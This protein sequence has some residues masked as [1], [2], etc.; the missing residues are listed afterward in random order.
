MVEWKHPYL[1]VFINL[2]E[3]ISDMFIKICEFPSR[4]AYLTASKNIN[5]S[6]I[7]KSFPENSPAFLLNI[8]DM[9]VAN[10]KK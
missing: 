5:L 6:N 10:F 7:F 4:I 1:W 2:L 9:F 3:N 8:S